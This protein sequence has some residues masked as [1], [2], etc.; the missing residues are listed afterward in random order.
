MW[1]YYYAYAE[2]HQFFSE[3]EQTVF[4][5][6]Y[7]V[8][9]NRRKKMAMAHKL[10]YDVV[11]TYRF[12]ERC[13]VWS[14][15]SAMLC[16]RLVACCFCFHKIYE[17]KRTAVYIQTTVSTQS[18]SNSGSI[19]TSD[20]KLQGLEEGGMAI[21]DDVDH[22]GVE[23]VTENL[24]MEMAVVV[25]EDA[26]SVDRGM[27]KRPVGDDLRNTLRAKETRPEDPDDHQQ[28]QQQHPTFRFHWKPLPR[29][30]E[31]P[32]SS[33][34]SSSYVSQEMHS[35]SAHVSALLAMKQTPSGHSSVSS[36]PSKLL[37]LNRRPGDVTGESPS[38]FTLPPIH[39]GHGPLS[40][41]NTSPPMR[42]I[43]LAALSLDEETLSAQRQQRQLF[44][45]YTPTSTATTTTTPTVGVLRSRSPVYHPPDQTTTR[46]A[47]S[48]HA[49]VH[50]DPDSFHTA[51]MSHSTDLCDFYP[52]LRS[53]L[54]SPLRRD[55]QPAH[56]GAHTTPP[57]DHDSSIAVEMPR[58]EDPSLSGSSP[59][60][61]TQESTSIP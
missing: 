59:P 46:S 49:H 16:L 39:T 40:T 61:P 3:K 12:W 15:C 45:A 6:A 42:S 11:A 26:P 18:N 30:A 1:L 21:D 38:Q 2:A 24:D 31:Q 9:L 34:L 57:L 54:R 35:H 55:A 7:I 60:P 58:T 37:S 44:R 10:A 25:R 43:D 19:E 56:D 27:T 28:Q 53:P 4:L 47:P 13:A 14:R 32:A 17:N 22:L 52:P 33:S 41:N 29:V 8:N 36:S 51:A 50:R 20:K 23:P 5:K 48:H